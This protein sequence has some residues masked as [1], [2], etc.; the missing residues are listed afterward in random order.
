MVCGAG[1]VNRPRAVTL[2]NAWLE[3]IRTHPNYGPGDQIHLN[4]KLYELCHNTS[5]S[6]VSWAIL[7]R[8]SYPNGYVT[9]YTDRD[10]EGRLVRS[11]TPPPL[12]IMELN[13]LMVHFNFFVGIGSKL[14][15]P[16][17]AMPMVSCRCSSM[18]TP[19]FPSVSTY[20]RSGRLSASTG[21]SPRECRCNSVA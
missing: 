20:I 8:Y 10:D 21:T 16:T 9:F 12:R 2:M 7:D 5:Q 13:P 3:S 19:I 1:R 6:N 14:E 17:A 15:A 11:W 18:D 4:V